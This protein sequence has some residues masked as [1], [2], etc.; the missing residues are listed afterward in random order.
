MV[1]LWWKRSQIN[2]C[3]HR[4]C[5]V[6]CAY[7]Y[8]W[9]KRMK[10]QN[11][12]GGKFGKLTVIAEAENL[13]GRVAW[14]C[15]CEC[16]NTAIVRATDLK[17]GNTKSCGCAHAD[18][19]LKTAEKNRGK[20]SKRLI[21]LAG[22]IFGRLTVIRRVEN[23]QKG[24]PM[25]ECQCE[26]GNKVNV[27]GDVLRYGMTQSCGCLARE[28][29]ATRIRTRYAGKPSPKL[30]DLTGKVFGY[31]TV[32]RRLT[33]EEGAK[34]GVA[35]WLCQCKCGNMTH[36]CSA[37]LVSGETR[38]CGCLGLENAT[39][40][41]LKHGDATYRRRQRLYGI[42]CT[43]RRRCM[44]PHVDAWKYYGV[45]GIKVCE[46]WAHDYAVFKA[47]ALA[48]GYQ[49][50]LTIDR[51]DP[52]GDYCPENCQWITAFENSSKAHRKKPK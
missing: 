13:G 32:I 10:K 42:R 5:I 33:E 21:D 40:A 41:K 15:Q 38:S 48:N 36:T 18:G 52:D 2:H 31:L 17:S 27:R 24:L 39:N 22:Q 11:L 47:W 46:E 8:N 19:V 29:A 23:N 1:L 4:P 34:R 25:W 9:G 3:K 51:I 14:K 50:G 45:K 6:N 20:P 35:K 26:C 44:D 37:K 28:K 43:M 30:K 16:G 12:V 49:A 7:F